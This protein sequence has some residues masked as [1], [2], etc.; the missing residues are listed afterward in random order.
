[1]SKP[2]PPVHPDRIWTLPNLIS[3][4]RLVVLLPLTVVFLAQ[5]RY[6]AA[7]VTI[8]L[9]GVTD[10]LDGFLARRM[11]LITEF[12]KNLDPWADR[13]AIV[14]LAITL[15]VEG[16]LPWPLVLAIVGTDLLLGIL[17][18]AW[19]G[20]PPPD[21]EVSFLGKARTAALLLSMPLLILY[22]ATGIHWIWVVGVVLFSIAT[23]GHVF[24]GFQYWR[25]MFRMHKLNMQE[26]TLAGE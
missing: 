8:V 25:I 26:R 9:L 19:F 20:G 15:V 6:D 1:M 13:I 4:S 2:A 22:A 23:I 24:A 10:W 3:V 21:L 11:D 18:L 14:V 7:L 5:Q 17:G 12:G 16:F